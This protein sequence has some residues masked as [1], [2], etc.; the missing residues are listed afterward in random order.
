LEFTPPEA[1]TYQLT[2]SGDGART[3]ILL[4]VGGAGQAVWPNL[5]NQRL[6]LTA[7]RDTYKP[8]ETAQIFIPNPFGVLAP[9]LVTVERSVVIRHQVLVLDPG[10]SSF[11]LSLSAD[12]APN[13]FLSVT[14]LGKNENGLPDFRQGYLDLAVDPSANFLN[15]TLTSQPQRAGP[16][17]EV[18][19]DILVTGSSGKP[20]QGEFSLSLVDLAVLALADPNS[21]D[22]VPAFYGPQPL[23]V[24][25]GQNLAVYTQRRTIV[26]PGLGGGGGEGIPS[27]TRERFPDTAYWNAAITTDAQGRARVSVSLPDSLTTWQVDLRGLTMDTRVGQATTQIIVNKDLLIRPVTPRFFVVGDHLR[28]A[29]IAQNNASNNL[30]TQ[31]S[32]QANGFNL[33]N[34]ES[35]NQQVNIPPGGRV[36]VEWWG[37]VQP[38]DS[39]DLIFNASS[40]NLRDVT[41]PNAGVIPVLRYA[42]PQT[43]STSGIMDE[44]GEQ[45]E[46]VSLPRSFGI[47]NRGPKAGSLHLEMTSS[48]AGVLLQGLEAMEH[49]PYECTEQIISRFLS[50]LETYRVLQKLNLET[51]DQQTR[52]QQV[53]DEGIKRIVARQNTGGGWGWWRGSPSDPFITAYALF[54]LLR[55]QDAGFAIPEDLVQNTIE[56]LRAGLVTPQTLH[57]TWQL[58]RL[59]FVHFMLAQAGVGDPAGLDALYQARAQL[60]PWSQALLA[61]SLDLTDAGSNQSR[62]LISDLESG[63]IRSST[64]AHW[65]EKTLDW[66]NMN[67]PIS[68]SAI[69]IY[70]LVQK[71]PATPLLADTVRY[72]VSHRQIDGE[73]DSTFSSTWALMALAKVLENSNQIDGGFDYSAW[74]NGSPIA[75]GQANSQTINPVIAEL[76]IGKLYPDTPNALVFKRD[77]GSGRLYYTASLNVYRPVDSVPSLQRGISVSRV[78]YPGVGKCSE[79]ACLPIQ[80]A[81]VGELVKVRLTLTLENDAYYLLVEDHLPSGSEILDTSLKTVQQGAEG[82]PIKPLFNLRQPFAGGWGWWLFS[83]PHIYDDHIAWAADYLPSGTYELIYTLQTLQPGE[84]RVLPARAWQF[85]FPDVQGNSPGTVFVIK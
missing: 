77:P 21:P 49:Y 46:L 28:L 35:A 5:P 57:E 2:I 79:P 41:R 15:V 40:G 80:N 27:V 6:R 67:T 12:D 64:G 78:Y 25:T 14:I 24:E 37:T 3:E 39:V 60:N 45:L 72:L 42:T 17:D 66:R 1:G 32:L 7:D 83:Q 23:G 44:A 82:E 71:D 9:M 73:W 29:A 85:Y 84:Y 33:D 47:A 63:A 19:F 52:L 30:L 38:I 20:A 16:G 81:K 18:T 54:G 51:P 68:T 22:I 11:S 65:E 26:P 4:W 34:P 62:T 48:L 53:L 10:G 36:Q 55:L 13:V 61:L 43:Y 50:N 56:F 70:A 75:E 8:G 59:A 58:D 31:V 74:L 76:P 69:V